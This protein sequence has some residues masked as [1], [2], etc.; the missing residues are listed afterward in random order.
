MG[1]FTR[2]A[3]G[4]GI[5]LL[6]LYYFAYPPFG[7][8]SAGVVSEGHYWII[9][10]NLIEVLVLM[11]IYL[12]PV[13]DFSIK[14]FRNIFSINSS[15]ITP[16]GS[17]DEKDGLKRR[18]LIKG[19]ATLPFFG[20]IICAAISRDHTVDPDALTG[21]TVALKRYDLKDLKGVLPKGI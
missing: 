5:V 16:R 2:L 18:E 20:G 17:I 3:A 10:R 12:F 9:N 14:N 15:K 8:Q 6:L 13:S 4:S 21:A 7:D 1:L 11:I 19:L